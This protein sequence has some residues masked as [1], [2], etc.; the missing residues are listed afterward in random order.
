M[1]AAK[2]SDFKSQHTI[3]LWFGYIKQKSNVHSSINN[4]FSTAECINLQRK[5]TVVINAPLLKI[6]YL[7]ASEKTL[8]YFDHTNCCIENTAKNLN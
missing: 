6:L 1:Q 3:P 4:E 2:I 8:V 5:K 7:I